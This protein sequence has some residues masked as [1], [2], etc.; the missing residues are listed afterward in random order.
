MTKALVTGG[1]GFLGSHLVERLVGEGWEVTVADL[2]SD[3]AESNLSGVAG[4]INFVEWDVTDPAAPEAIG[5]DF[6]Y[7][8]HLAA[9]ASPSMCEKDPDRAF[10]VNVQGTYNVLRLASEMRLKKFLFSSTATVYGPVPKYTPI[11]ELHPVPADNNVYSVTKLVG[12]MVCGFFRERGVPVVVLRLFTTFG[13]RQTTDYLFPTI[14]KQALEKKSVELW[15]DKPTRDFNY[16]DDTV[17]AFLKAAES[18]F[19]GGPINVGSGTETKVGDVARKIAGS[20]GAEVVFLDREVVGPMRLCSDSRKAKEE[21][22]WSPSV[23][24]DEGL[25]RTIE[26]Y[27]KSRPI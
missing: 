17:D 16:V 10:R 1:G 4:K 19:V 24:F 22:G 13:P 25:K 2:K 8:F 20:L 7:V 23:G 12:E 27:K 15:S 18:G 5:R 21:I 3:A 9:F 26:W 14:I 6:D 11:D